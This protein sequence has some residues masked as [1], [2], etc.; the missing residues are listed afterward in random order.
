MIEAARMGPLRQNSFLVV[1]FVFSS[2][3]PGEPDT[4]PNYSRAYNLVAVATFS[5]V[6]T[7]R[8]A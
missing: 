5:Y 2:R 8:S 6:P 7:V 1:I 3:S 4:A